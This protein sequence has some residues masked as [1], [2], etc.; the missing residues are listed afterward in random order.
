M[1]KNT[2]NLDR[3]HDFITDSGFHQYLTVRKKELVILTDCGTIG[4][5]KTKA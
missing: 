1:T 2:K 4:G 3:F 5:K